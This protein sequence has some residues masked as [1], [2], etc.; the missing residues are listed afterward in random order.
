MR[1]LNARSLSV[2][3]V[4]L[5]STY[6]AAQNS[7]RPLQI[8]SIDVEGGQATLLVS[9]SRQSMLVDTG[10]PGF[11]GRDADRIVSAAKSAGLQQIDYV[12]ITHYH[13]DH[14]GGVAQLADRIKIGTFVDHG[15][16]LEEAEQT[17]TGY[18]TYQ[19]VLAKTNAK[20]LVLKPG[21]H[22]PI[23]GL[24]VQVIT[25]A[26][27]HINQPLQGAGQPNPLCQ[28]EPPAP[29]DPTENS[30]SL[31]V[32][33]TYEKFRF[34]DL[35]DLTKQK[36]VQLVCPNNLVGKIDVFLVSHHG[37]NQSNSNALVRAVHP[38]VA[39][40]N[41][42]AHKGGSPEAWQ[43]VHDS[44]GVEDLWQLHYAEDSSKGRNTS[45]NLIANLNG[46]E[47]N[48]IKLVAQSD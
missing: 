43:T 16:N 18:A 10:W 23:S 45:E 1:T 34:L 30:A 5:L 15:P 40:M 4:L 3:V 42:G 22:I 36:E 29:E 19:E 48:Y 41:N 11:N 2:S 12:V 46:A 37:L 44:P 35:G 13:Q 33:V 28:A 14:V 26:R 8:Y 7:G 31:G 6:I 38:R 24:D 47:G 27:Q 25:A 21:D 9:P 17:K 20:H 39:I 32:L